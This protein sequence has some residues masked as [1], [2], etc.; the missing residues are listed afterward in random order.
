MG[1]EESSIGHCS[2]SS[3]NNAQGNHQQIST[4]SVQHNS[5]IN[6]L[7]FQKKKGQEIKLD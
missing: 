4:I 1:G 2:G 7:N 6:P 5:N 3:T